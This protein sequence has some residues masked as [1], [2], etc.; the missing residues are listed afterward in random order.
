VAQ[1]NVIDQDADVQTICQLLQAGVVGVLVQRKVHGERLGGDL[2]A[3]FRGN[4][5][6]ERVE[7]GLGAGNEDEIVAL[8]CEGERELLA[9]AIRSTCDKSP[10]AAGTKGAELVERSVN[11]W[12]IWLMESHT[13][14]PGRTNK[15]SRTLM[16]LTMGAANAAMPTTRKP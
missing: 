11:D 4:V 9:N 5:G 10:G 8:G 16:V 3:I 12:E 7:L 15:L 14:F 6:G 2:R 13:D 1:S